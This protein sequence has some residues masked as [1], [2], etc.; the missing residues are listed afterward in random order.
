[1]H[2]DDGFDVDAGSSE[3]NGNT[4]SGNS[5]GKKSGSGS[6]SSSGGRSSLRLYPV[7]APSEDNSRRTQDGAS[8]NSYALYGT[9]YTG[10]GYGADYTI[11]NTDGTHS[12]FTGTLCD[13]NN[14]NAGGNN[15]N[16]AVL[17][18]GTYMLRT[19]GA[20][21]PYKD[22]ISFEFC[23]VHGGASYEVVF[24]LDCDGHCVPT[25]VRSAADVCADLEQSW[26]FQETPIFL[27][28]SVQL[29]GTALPEEEL[30]ESEVG[31]IRTALAQ[32][33]SE[34]SLH[35]SQAT[36][37]DQV[38]V[39][40]WRVLPPTTTTSVSRRLL[41][42]DIKSELTTHQLDFRVALVAESFRLSAMT[43]AQS[44]AMEADISAYLQRSIAAGIFSIKVTN[45]A[46]AR[47]V[48]SLQ[49]SLTFASFLNLAVKHTSRSNHASVTMA[50][51][52]IG[53]GVLAG[54]IVGIIVF[55]SINYSSKKNTVQNED[56]NCETE[57]SAHP[58][59]PSSAVMKSSSLNLDID[60]MTPSSPLSG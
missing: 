26:M 48:S 59:L 49:S 53:V 40:G 5:F 17:D 18:P 20:L 25:S 44:R 29:A 14:N 28:G 6:S 43:A 45:V 23:G 41:T 2:N 38:S 8:L 35:S 55:R 27:E 13:A 3:E 54:I 12:Y 56:T 32:E 46:K 52:F 7:Y 37:E 19:T 51:L 50:E 15:C 60:D 33:L 58:M 36:T 9:W 39:I 30:S 4:A 42:S 1:M 10:T 21:S 22:T 31:V 34:A 47:G 57:N 11:S 24:V 16:L